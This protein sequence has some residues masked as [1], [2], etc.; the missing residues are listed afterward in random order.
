MA[1]EKNKIRNED[2]AVHD[3]PQGMADNM[4]MMETKIAVLVEEVDK[5]CNNCGNGTYSVSSCD[6]VD[7][8]SSNAPIDGDHLSKND[9]CEKQELT[10]T[11]ELTL[12]SSC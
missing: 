10:G 9:A 3:L 5:A 11:F 4:S 8:I 2:K 12:Y 6:V 1:R 7:G